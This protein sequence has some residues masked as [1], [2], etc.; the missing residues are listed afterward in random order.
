MHKPTALL[1][2][3]VTATFTLAGCGKS[4]S[5]D[6]SKLQKAFASSEG[7]VKADAAKIVDAVKAGNW[8]DAL[9]S[10]KSLASNAKLTPEQTQAIKDVIAQVQAKV[11]AAVQ[12]GAKDAQKTAEDLKKSVGG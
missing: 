3:V 9:S 12:Q 5:I 7:T 4:D 6:T 11:T 2:P 10:L 1:A 8:A